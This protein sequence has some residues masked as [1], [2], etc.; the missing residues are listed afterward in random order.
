MKTFKPLALAG[1]GLLGACV[2]AQDAGAPPV[3]GGTPAP[4]KP[5]VAKAA[6]GQV[7]IQLDH[8][9]AR[10]TFSAYYANLSQ[11][12][13]KVRVLT[14]F[15][16]VQ[17][18]QRDYFIA[19]LTG[20]GITDTVIFDIDEGDQRVRLLAILERFKS[21][22]QKTGALVKRMAGRK[23]A[24]E[25]ALSQAETKLV[26]LRDKSGA[27]ADLAKVEAEIAKLKDA[28]AV[29]DEISKMKVISGEMGVAKVHMNHPPYSFVG[30]FEPGAKQLYILRAG[31]GVQISYQ[32]VDYYIDLLKRAPEFKRLLLEGESKDARIRAEI[33]ALYEKE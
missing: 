2:Y 25:K 24:S 12:R 20:A 6:D 7:R 19:E 1:L 26:E 29:A 14:Q 17:A 33:K 3:P 10:R 11:A 16:P 28:I 4:A 23:A 15:D 31:F 18:R 5:A 21:E 22:A 9:V 27:A 32:D 8:D 30:T 13:L